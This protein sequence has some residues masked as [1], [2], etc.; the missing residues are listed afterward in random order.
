M[1]VLQGEGAAFSD[2]QGILVVG[3]RCSLLG[4]QHGDFASSDL[5]NFATMSSYDGLIG[6][7]R[8]RIAFGTFDFFHAGL[9]KI[10]G[11]G[12]LAAPSRMVVGDW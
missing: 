6:D 1:E 11:G 7:S 9:L 10:V 2:P 4:G 3:N 5:V 8:C 12:C